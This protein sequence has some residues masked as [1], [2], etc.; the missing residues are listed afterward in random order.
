M[1]IVNVLKI[2]IKWWMAQFD[3]VIRDIDDKITEIYKNLKS[4]QS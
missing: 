3:N 1:R 2:K 4:K